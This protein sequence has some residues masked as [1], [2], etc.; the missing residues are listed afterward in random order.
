MLSCELSKPDVPVQWAKDG[1]PL[2]STEE[3]SL[4][5]VGT[6]HTLT[7]QNSRLDDEAEYSLTTG[8]LITKAEL[9][10]DGQYLDTIHTLSRG[11]S[12]YLDLV[13]QK[14]LWSL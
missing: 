2:E 7:I 9:L 1:K 4:S 12:I 6:V 13:L 8:D 14:L 11:L 10:V 5:R 3:I